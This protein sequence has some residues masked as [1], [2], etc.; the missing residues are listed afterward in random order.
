W[1]ALV[2]RGG[3]RAATLAGRGGHLE[4]RRSVV[5]AGGGFHLEEVRNRS[6]AQPGTEVPDLPI[7]G[8]ADQHGRGQPPGTELVDHLQRELPFRPVAH[9]VRDLR[10]GPS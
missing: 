6:L 1:W 5:D 10:F 4:P 7:A 2:A 3:E 8:V 9:T